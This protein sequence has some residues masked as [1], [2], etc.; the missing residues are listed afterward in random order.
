MARVYES[1]VTYVSIPLSKVDKT[2][3]GDLLV[4][5]KATDSSVDAD[6]QIVDP[7]WSAKALGEWLTT[8]GNVRVMHSPQHLPAGKGV[9]LD[10]SAGDGHW[11]RS[12]VVEPTAKRLVDEGVLQA[13]SIGIMNPKIIRDAAAKGGR[14]VGGTIHEVSLVDRPANA[15]CK[16]SLVKSAGG[17]AG[18]S[19]VEV[20]EWTGLDD[21]LTK[22]GKAPNDHDDTAD[23]SPDQRL[24]GDDG[25]PDDEHPD[26]T[27]SPDDDQDDDSQ[28]RPAGKAA[29]HAAVA[30]WRD[31]EPRL[32]GTALTGTAFLA[33][34]AAYQRWEDQGDADGLDGTETGYQRWLSK[35]AAPTTPTGTAAGGDVF[36]FAD[37][38]ILGKI[39]AAVAAPVAKG[40][41]SCRRCGEAY[42]ADAKARRCGSC[43]KKLPRAEESVGK[44]AKRR[45]VPPDVMPAGPHREPDGS[46]VQALEHDAGMPTDPDPRVDMTP[47]SVKGSGST[48]DYIV[49][50]MHDAVCPAYAW[51]TVAA[52]Y[53]SL[54]SVADAVDPAWFAPR[55]TAAVT[56]GD[57]AAVSAEAAAANLAQ[58]LVKGVDVGALADARAQLHKS[59][60]DLYPNVSLTPGD[61]PSP[62][63]FQ[64]PYINAGH[65]PLN[66]M[67]GP[68]MTSVPPAA[69]T[70]N[71][72]DFTRGLITDGHQAASPSNKGNSLATPTL[73]SGAARGYY[74]GAAQ[75]AATNAMAALHD[76]LVGVLPNHCRMAASPAVMPPGMQAEGRPTPVTM[77]AALPAA[78]GERVGKR[79]KVRPGKG[80][81]RQIV[82][83]VTSE[84]VDAYDARIAALQAEID[85]LSSQPDPAQA[86]LRGVVRTPPVDK[87]VGAAPVQKRNLQVEQQEAQAAEQAAYVQYLSVLT[88]SANPATREQAETRLAELTS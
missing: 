35:Q 81:V 56:A 16:F 33:K 1:D 59:F 67:S 25:D 34:R 65:A 8:G 12:K 21:A 72:D 54:K 58:H 24:S 32:D 84:L 57:M 50:R 82:K 60:S 41:K 13:Y 37:H 26:D 63:R 75:Q 40:A 28:T 85:E 29:Y 78:P 17:A 55:V 87:A 53:P 23:S 6:Q 64:R 27:D 83:A 10:T 80:T 42:D 76:H 45:L 88:K 22:A 4:W 9:V 74:P 20:A 39:A 38:P 48:V 43:G 18:G 61:P 5:G 44:S 73:R 51:D 11:L 30:A 52:A 77:P 70:I 68:H 79:A 3:D 7:D 49:A 86:P 62:G 14:I 31:A 19:A 15:N 46:A 69:H 47:A 2:P 71:A 66:A 36:D